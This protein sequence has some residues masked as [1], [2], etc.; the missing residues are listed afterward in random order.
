MLLS[1]DRQVLNGSEIAYLR[2]RANGLVASDTMT[3]AY[4]GIRHEH[5]LNPTVMAFAEFQDAHGSLS[6]ASDLRTTGREPRA[7][8][9]TDIQTERTFDGYMVN[10]R[11]VWQHGMRQLSESQIAALITR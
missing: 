9:V 10:I 8:V 3:F 1:L 6:V 2:Q 11:Q 7:R 4:S 5:T